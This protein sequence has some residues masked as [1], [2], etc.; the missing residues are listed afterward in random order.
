MQLLALVTVK[1]PME[2]QLYPQQLMIPQLL[3]QHYRKQLDAVVMVGIELF[4][5]QTMLPGISFTTSGFYL[6]AKGIFI[7]EVNA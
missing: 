5:E 6:L 3:T 7:G 4:L 1:L 2:N